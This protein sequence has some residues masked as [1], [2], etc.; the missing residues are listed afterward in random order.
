MTG[1]TKGGG[2][3]IP[4][5]VLTAEEVRALVG[6]N[7]WGV[8]STV[9]NAQP[10]AVPIIYGFDTAF[11]AVLRDGR[12]VRNLEANPRACLTVVEIEHLATAWRSV[13]AVGRARWLEQ[14]DAMRAAIDVIR[15]QY[16][17]LPTRTGAG[18]DALRAQGH[19]VLCLEVEEMTG[20]TN[21]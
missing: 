21:E 17:G 10:Y 18:V 16:P 11:Y 9:D 5:R 1:T 2:S 3:R 14:D 15:A 7:Y 8:L 20:R 13:V 12:K 4:P 19:R 6:R